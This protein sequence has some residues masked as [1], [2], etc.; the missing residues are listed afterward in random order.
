MLARR[1]RVSAPTGVLLVG[2]VPLGSAEEVF[3]T[4]S[5]AIGSRLPAV[6]DGETGERAD[7]IGWQSDLFL[8]HPQLEASG[9]IGRY[10]PRP[11][12]RLRPGV[13]PGEV[14]FDRL[15]Y[16]EAALTSYP[17][18]AHLKE[19]G[20]IPAHVRFQ[21]CLPSP[22]APVQA[23][24]TEGDQDAVRPAYVGRM[25]D[26][27]DE[28]AAAIPHS[29]LA[30]QWDVA[31]EMLAF[32]R[33]GDDDGMAGRKASILEALARSGNRVPRDVELGFHLC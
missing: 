26:E 28:I 23:W 12:S 25:L 20:V 7:F 16:S 4:V 33:M 21:V 32:E 3:R 13:N 2:S 11:K 17:I 6:P 9:E 27:V 31:S 5:G 22:L 8:H 30:M 18:F 29:E 1:L 24:I 19:E 15:G 14:R 10:N